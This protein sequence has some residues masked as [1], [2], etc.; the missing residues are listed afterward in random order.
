MDKLNYGSRKYFRLLTNRYMQP[1]PKKLS[2]FPSGVLIAHMYQYRSSQKRQTLFHHFT[3]YSNDKLFRRAITIIQVGPLL[4]QLA[5][6]S[7]H[8]HTSTC[9]QD[10]SGESYERALQCLLS[11]I[12]NINLADHTHPLMPGDS[13]HL[14]L[15]ADHT[16]DIHVATARDKVYHLVSTDVHLR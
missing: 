9:P 6:S 13:T 16:H 12:H 15:S 14:P 2:A 3:S 5:H 10:F 11:A 7:A 4:C 8:T 1:L